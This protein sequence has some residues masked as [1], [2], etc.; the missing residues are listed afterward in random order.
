MTINIRSVSIRYEF[1]EISVLGISYMCCI[2]DF[3]LRFLK[4]KKR[5]SFRRHKKYTKWGQTT[6]KKELSIDRATRGSD[7]PVFTIRI[8]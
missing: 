1:H 8:K 2:H 7:I 5:R 4:K 3:L 6:A